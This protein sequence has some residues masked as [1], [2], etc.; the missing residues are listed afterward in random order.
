[1]GLCYRCLGDDHLGS[2]CKW[3]RECRIDGCRESH[4]RLLHGQK[5]RNTNQRQGKQSPLSNNQTT[6]TRTGGSSNQ[7]SGQGGVNPTIDQPQTGVSG[8]SME[9]EAN[10]G[11]ATLETVTEHEMESV[12]LRTVPII[13]KNGVAIYW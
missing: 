3:N 5:T 7:V 4:H 11:L 2:A 1:M 9:G 13:L 10:T 12:A 8:L 6:Q